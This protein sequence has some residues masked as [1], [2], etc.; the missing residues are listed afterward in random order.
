MIKYIQ[1]PLDLFLIYLDV[2]R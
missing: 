2:C 1:I